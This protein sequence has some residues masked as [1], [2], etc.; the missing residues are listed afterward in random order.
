MKRGK[1]KIFLGYAKGVGK[2]Y[3]MLDEAKIL[4]NEGVDIVIG[5]MTPNQSKTTLAQ[6]TTLETMPYK[7]Y[8][9]E[10]QIYLEFDLDG[11]LQRKPNTIVIDEL[12][13]DNVPGMRHKKRYQDVEE[14][15]RNGINVYTTINIKNIDSLHDFVESITGKRVDERIP[16][17]IFDAAD[18]IEL[19]DISPKDLLLR[20][21]NIEGTDAEQGV[22]FPKEI[23]TEENLIALREIALRKAA[24]QIHHSSYK[25]ASYTTKEHILICLSTSPTNEKVIRTASRMAEAFHASFTAVYVENETKQ[26]NPDAQLQLDQNIK[27]AEALGAQVTMLYG[28]DIALQISEYARLSQVTK[29]VIGRTVRKRGRFRGPS[30]ID[31]L[32]ETVPTIDIY[33]IPD[34]ST[35]YYLKREST[36]QKEVFHWN[37]GFKALLVIFGVTLVGGL[38]AY[39]GFNESNI[40]VVYL[41]GVLAIAMLTEGRIWSSIASVIS[42]LVFNYFFTKPQFSLQADD[43]GYPFTFVFMF[44]AAFVSSTLTT[45]LKARD[46]QS[47]KKA[48]RTDVLLETSLRLQ[49]ASSYSE[50]VDAMGHQVKKLLNTTVIIYTPENKQLIP[51]VYSDL[52]PDYIHH[53][54]LSEDERNVAQWVYRNNKRAGASTDT[55][56]E[57]QMA[58]MAIRSTDKVVA[59]LAVHNEHQTI[60][61]FLRNLLVSLIN[62]GGIA[63]EKAAL[64][65]QQHHDAIVIEQEK[66]RSTILRTISHDLRTPL[67]TILGNVDLLQ[68]GT[69]DDGEVH[70]IYTDIKN[71]GIWLMDLIE[72]I[73]AMT[74]IDNDNLIIQFEGEVLEDL[75][76]E[77]LHRVSGKAKHHTILVDDAKDVVLVNVDSKLMIQVFTNLIDN[78]LKYTPEGTQ[79]RIRTDNK[80]LEKVTIHVEDEGPGIADKQH[81]FE[82]FYT[83]NQ[84]SRRGMGLGLYLVNEI[85]K[86]HGGSITVSD[87]EPQGVRF[88]VSLRRYV[89]DETANI[90]R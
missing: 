47:A 35:S 38:F 9:N 45:K 44:V 67:T 28:D 49:K 56:S 7:T 22:L 90:N 25:T 72:N 52:S 82:M 68:H 24:D 50:I 13:H 4:K 41:L 16:D 70:R 20:V 15:L 64:D 77:S 80:D 43:S 57:S 30:I 37:D 53:E 63:L 12:A 3:A 60:D 5:Y 59:V 18:T 29:I 69:L 32:S 65:A 73:L 75:I 31:Q 81:L 26:L 46:L 84:D 34:Q 48:Y 87:V 17:V 6:A 62:E 8:K 39:L 88:S 58:Y 36:L 1:L 74:K 55:M 14:L 2:T 40:I 21:A 66:L 54:L 79:I 61:P 78:A 89:I 51:T 85:V 42:V 19:I 23:F 71:D 10:S 76:A 27:L 83:Q 86:A 33:V 11:A